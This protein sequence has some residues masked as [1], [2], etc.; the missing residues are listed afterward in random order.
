MTGDKSAKTVLV[1][2]DSASM[3]WILRTFL[4]Q[5]GFGTVLEASNGLAAW[6]LLK[7]HKVDVILSDWIMPAMNGLD[8]LEKVRADAN[9]RFVPIIVVTVNGQQ[10]QVIEALNMGC[11]DYVVKPMNMQVLAGKLEKVLREQR[12]RP[13]PSG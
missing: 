7:R 11:T 6:N 12:P 10:D 8:L 13:G 3:R 9:L 1:A 5:L 4:R 2:D